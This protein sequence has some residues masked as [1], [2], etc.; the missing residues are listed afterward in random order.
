MS[1][2][3]AP[4]HSLLPSRFAWLMGLHAENYH[5]L[6]RL[7]APQD[8]AL[9]SYVSSLDDGL[10]VRLDVLER[11]RYT[12]DLHLTYCF[13][14]SQT[15]EQAPSAQLRMY[16][17]AHMAEVLD[18]RADRRLIRAIGPLQPARDVFQR[19]IRMGSFLNRWLEYLAEQGHSIGT[20][21][22]SVVGVAPSEPP[23]QPPHVGAT[24]AAIAGK[25]GHRG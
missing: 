18:C 2:V 16:H 9:G 15:G 23:F 5:R 10:D 24:S 25:E 19:R 4:S 12:L 7:F 11:H 13:V 8:L 14:D 1:V 21:E 6:A 20:L 17:D 3:L 22:P